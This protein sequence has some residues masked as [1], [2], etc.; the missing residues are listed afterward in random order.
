MLQSSLPFG[1]DASE[2]AALWQA[3]SLV[4]LC[5]VDG[6]AMVM[7]WGVSARCSVEW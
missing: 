3:S 7:P 6:A 2:L 5:L 4:A 1:G